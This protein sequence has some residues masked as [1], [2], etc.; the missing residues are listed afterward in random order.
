M[1]VGCANHTALN[2][3]WHA[4]QLLCPNGLDIVTVECAR[5]N[6][7]PYCMW[8]VKYIYTDQNK[9]IIWATQNEIK[10]S[11]TKIVQLVPIGLSVFRKSKRYDATNQKM[12]YCVEFEVTTCTCAKEDFESIL[13]HLNFGVFLI[14][15]EVNYVDQE[16]EVGITIC[17]IE[18]I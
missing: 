5:N 4:F 9:D 17:S 6:K 14:K 8:L 3:T 10:Q 13:M 12:T 11:F 2:A 7:K 18:S 15:N 16:R 1:I